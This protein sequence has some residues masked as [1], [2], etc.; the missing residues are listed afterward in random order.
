MLDNMDVE[1][2][3]ATELHD[4]PFIVH[5]LLDPDFLDLEQ[6]KTIRLPHWNPNARAEIAEN[7]IQVCVTNQ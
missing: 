2:R 6:S 5:P 1:A 3:S 4:S 7:E